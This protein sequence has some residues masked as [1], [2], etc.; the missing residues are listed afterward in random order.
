MIAS[1]EIVIQPGCTGSNGIGFQFRAVLYNTFTPVL[2]LHW[3]FVNLS[4]RHGKAFSGAEILD[5]ALLKAHKPSAKSQ[6]RLK[7][8]RFAI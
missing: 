1:E 7:L 5:E 6:L 4:S 2:G 3:I 8:P